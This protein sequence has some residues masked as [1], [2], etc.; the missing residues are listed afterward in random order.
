MF[1]IIM[2]KNEVPDLREQRFSVPCFMSVACLDIV[3]SLYSF[4]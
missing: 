2:K 3:G 1:S 4:S